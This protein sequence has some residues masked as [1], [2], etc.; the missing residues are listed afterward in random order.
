MCEGLSSINGP[1]P[2]HPMFLKENSFTSISARS[3]SNSICEGPSK[4]SG[5]IVSHFETDAEKARRT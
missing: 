2:P 4:I 3:N 1:I 5:P